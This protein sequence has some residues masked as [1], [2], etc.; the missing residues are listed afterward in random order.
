MLQNVK[1]G[2]AVSILHRTKLQSI[3][4]IGSECQIMKLVKD[5][6]VL[7]SLD[8]AKQTSG[9]IGILGILVAIGLWLL[10]FYF[11]YRL[12]LQKKQQP[13]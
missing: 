12:K 13:A 2:D 8:D 11:K 6:D 7:Y 5:K 1:V 3:I 9:M 4:G 10:Y